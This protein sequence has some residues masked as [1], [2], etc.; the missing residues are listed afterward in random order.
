MTVDTRPVRASEQLEWARLEDYLRSALP[1]PSQA[2]LDLVR[3]VL[4]RM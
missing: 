2:A 4:L 1:E 3:R